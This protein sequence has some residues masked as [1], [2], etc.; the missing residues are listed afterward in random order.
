M[1]PLL[2]ERVF[3]YPGCKTK[4]LIILKEF[5]NVGILI[6]HGVVPGAFLLF[7]FIFRR[8]VQDPHSRN[9]RIFMSSTAFFLLFNYLQLV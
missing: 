5:Q 6:C 7:G 3:S 8:N 1:V 9:T 2:L 4:I